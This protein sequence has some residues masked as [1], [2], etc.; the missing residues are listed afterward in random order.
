[1]VVGQLQTDISSVTWPREF[2]LSMNVSNSS[3]QENAKDKPLG[4][5][6]HFIF[7]YLFISDSKTEQYTQ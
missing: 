1:M 5:R 2:R 4:N 7:I 3:Q 6:K